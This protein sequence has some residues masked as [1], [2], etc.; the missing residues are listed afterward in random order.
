MQPPYTR[1]SR[2]VID[3]KI[4]LKSP[5]S[6]KFRPAMPAALLTAPMRPMQDPCRRNM[7]LMPDFG[8]TSAQRVLDFMAEARRS[9][10]RVSK[11]AGAF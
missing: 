7:Q 4:W 1:S 3:F 9:H 8:P 2:R 11:C 6:G 5:A 10:Q